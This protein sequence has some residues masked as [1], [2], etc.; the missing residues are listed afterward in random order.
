MR[1]LAIAVALSASLAAQ[2][3]PSPA[4]FR[5]NSEREAFLRTA[6]IVTEPP[7]ARPGWRATLDD[8]T[9]RHDAGVETA[10]GTG[11]LQGHYKSNIAAYELDRLLE[12]NMVPATVERTV[13]GKPA[14]VVWWLD[15]VAMNE[16]ARRTKKVEPPDPDDWTRQMHAVRVF[17]EL[18]AN[19]YRDT[20]PESYL[21]SRWDNLLITKDWRIRLV[22]H[23]HTFRVGRQ[24]E[25]PASLTRCDR[26]LL[27]KLRALN[28]TVLEQRLA[29]YLT[30]EQ[31]DALEIRR[32]LLVKHFD[33]LMARRGENAVLYDL[34]APR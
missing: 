17:D 18:V 22:D 6:S 13:S 26:A 16:Q 8:G 10:D 5:T 29:K 9:S 2:Q 11:P 15:D 20:R 12:L 28:G 25:D 4:P 1:T 27:R 7:A 23:T 31:L 3:P 14:A 33:D 21:S 32:A 34:A 24:L 19:E 30:R